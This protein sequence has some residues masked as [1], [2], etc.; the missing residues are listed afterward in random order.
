M[1]IPNSI[2]ISKRVRDQFQTIKN[3]TGLPNNVLSRIALMLAMESGAVAKPGSRVDAGGQTLS[4]DLMFG[5]YAEIYD[6]LIR[7][8]LVERESQLPVG[9]AIGGLIEVGAHKMAHCRSIEEVCRLG[10]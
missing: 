6:I 10:S 2:S 8:Y 4:R 7:Q 3:K 9:E 5:E 1:D